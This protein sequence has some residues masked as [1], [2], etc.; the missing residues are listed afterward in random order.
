M[1]EIN[2]N[3]VNEINVKLIWIEKWLHI[4]KKNYLDII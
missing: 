4:V 2:S 1:V 3:E